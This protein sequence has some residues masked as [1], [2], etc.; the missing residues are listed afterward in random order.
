MMN[1]YK[2]MLQWIDL[3]T[4][5]TKG[6]TLARHSRITQGH[7]Y[8]DYNPITRSYE[9]P[10][11]SVPKTSGITQKK[12]ERGGTKGRGGKTGGRGKRRCDCL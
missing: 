3:N 8:M 2:S 6:S 11:N 4:T 5:C 10:Q 7:Q 1:I 9:T 12:L